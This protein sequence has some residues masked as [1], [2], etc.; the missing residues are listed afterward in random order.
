[1]ITFFRRWL[2]SWPA[3]IL[4]GLVLVAFAITGIGDPFGTGGVPTGAVAK[5][6]TRNI[7]ENEVSRAFERLVRTIREQDPAAVATQVA[8]EGGVAV[9]VN[10]II[11]QAALAELGTS[12]GLSASDRAIGAVIAGVQAFQL[13]G[14][15]DESTYRAVL[16]QQRLSDK[17]LREGIH[18]DLV[19]RQLLTP[20][21]AS[22]GVPENMALPYAQLLVDIH[23]GAVALA[24]IM[25][26][27]APTAAEIEKF[28]NANKAS[29]TLP[30]RRT[31]RY[32]VID[33]DKVTGNIKVSD[34]Q[35]AAAFA[36]DAAKYGAAATRKLQQVVVAD[37][38]AAKAIVAAAATEGFAA[39]A[40]RLGG[41]GAA[42]IA[43]G[44]Q[45]QADFAKATSPAVA[46]AAF[47]AP[48]G[49]ITQP[50]KT[51]FGWHVVKVEA[52][53]AGKT[54]AAGQGQGGGRAARCRRPHRGCRS[55]RPHRRRCGGRQELRR[56]CPRQ[57]P[58]HPHPGCRHR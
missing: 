48:V 57:W 40:Q 56:C 3:L 21:T 47:T 18:D 58:D 46:S 49:G 11:G 43:L 2:T 38:A 8:K 50:I 10:Q 51:D 52:T 34:E 44:D 27:A 28:Y 45:T 41:F 23:R 19:R 17:E 16:A 7:S 9:A 54:L 15:F 39:A 24:P 26:G 4:L 35:I 22:L 55:R 31:F 30:E 6:G 42:D 32:A 14:K 33:N 20:V 25:P 5:V 36:K 12:M 53:G 13:G 1:M 37:E 29:F